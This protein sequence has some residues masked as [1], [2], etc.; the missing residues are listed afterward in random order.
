METILLGVFL[1]GLIFTVLNFVL[2]FAELE[3][4]MPE[5][6]DVDLGGG[7]TAISPWNVSTILAFLTWFGGIGYLLTSQTSYVRLTVLALATLG[8][9]IG[10]VVVF[11]VTVRILLPG[12][13]APMRA[14]D[15][16]LEGTL[17][18]VT[19]PMGGARTGE[20]IFSKYGATRS[21]GARSADGSPL[22]RDTEVVLLRYEKGIAYVEPLDKLLAERPAPSGGEVLRRDSGGE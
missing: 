2:G 9:L 11:L 1:F 13:T 3:I 19:M 5:F 14:E 4:P 8:G 12:Q 21:E 10:A 7:Q 17:A 6:L 20:V 16:R 15:S 18:R 22:L